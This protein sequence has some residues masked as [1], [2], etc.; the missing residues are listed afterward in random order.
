MSLSVMQQY[1]VARKV[2][3][4]ALELGTLIELLDG[5][6]QLRADYGPEVEDYL[7]GIISVAEWQSS[8]EW[9]VSRRDLLIARAKA[10]LG[11]DL[12]ALRQ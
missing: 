2:H 8:R 3:G 7:S 9:A 11:D 4:L 1:H 5:L 10:K 6:A 12:G